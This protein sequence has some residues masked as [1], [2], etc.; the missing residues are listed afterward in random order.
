M[1]VKG[2]FKSTAFKCIITLLAILLVCGVFLTVANGFLQVS[3]EE[4]FDRAIKK[5]YG[6]DVTV[7]R[8]EDLSD[9]KTKAK[10]AS[11]VR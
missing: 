8:I 9:Q 3:E 5:L 2:F 1:T 6:K 4:R 11:A 10:R 7:E